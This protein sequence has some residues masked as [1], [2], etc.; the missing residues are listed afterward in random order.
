MPSKFVLAPPVVVALIVVSQFVKGKIGRFK[1]PTAL[2]TSPALKRL[3]I[4][5]HQFPVHRLNFETVLTS[6]AIYVLLR[7]ISLTI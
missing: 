1:F 3:S 6:K 5:P 4:S 7:Y 2:R